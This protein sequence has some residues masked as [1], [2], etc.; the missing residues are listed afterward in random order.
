[1]AKKAVKIKKTL[2]KKSVKKK[3]LRKKRRSVEPLAIKKSYI[4]IYIKEKSSMQIDPEIFSHL[5]KVVESM[6]DKAIE[7]AKENK[8]GTIRKQDF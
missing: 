7:R 3:I 2:D 8:R 6:C 4:K 5:S 1:M